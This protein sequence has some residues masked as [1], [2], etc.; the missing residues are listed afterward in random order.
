M[1]I[2]NAA[3]HYVARPKIITAS[4]SQCH[5][6]TLTSFLVP[7]SFNIA[8]VLFVCQQL[9]PET[10]TGYWYQKT[11]QCV[12]PLRHLCTSRLNA[13]RINLGSFDRLLWTRTD[14]EA[15]IHHDSAISWLTACMRWIV[16]WTKFV[17]RFVTRHSTRYNRF[18]DVTSGE[19]PEM[20][21]SWN[22]ESAWVHGFWPKIRIRSQSVSA[23]MLPHLIV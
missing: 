5:T 12:W 20:C 15:I 16:A 11:G 21:G 7:V 23:I 13:S 8:H 1:L 19:R 17:P 10:G 22:F 9:T 6:K 4:S 2:A 14:R 3:L 18:T